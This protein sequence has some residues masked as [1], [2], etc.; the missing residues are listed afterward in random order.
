MI[1]SSLVAQYT[2]QGS[3]VTAVERV[4]SLAQKTPHAVDVAQ[5]NMINKA[6]DQW[7]LRCQ[8]EK[9]RDLSSPQIEI[10]IFLSLY[11]HRDTGWKYETT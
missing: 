7:D 4:Q 8:L 3:S 1:G 2:A 11:I 10:Y 9:L 5:K 6:N